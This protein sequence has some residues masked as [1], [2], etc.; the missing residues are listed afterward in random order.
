MQRIAHLL[1][2]F[3]AALLGMRAASA[4]ELRPPP[5]PP[6]ESPQSPPQPPAVPPDQVSGVA[7]PEKEPRA[8]DLFWIPRALLFVPRWA[9]W[10]AVQPVRLGAWAYGRYLGGGSG[11]PGRT[12]TLSIYPI[13]RID[14]SY[15]LTAGARLV[16]RNVIGGGERLGLRADFSG[17]YRRTFGASLRSGDRFGRRFVAELAARYE[18]RPFERFSGIGDTAELEAPPAMQLDPTAASFLTRFREDRARAVLTGDVRITG[19]LW[20]RLSAALT[21]RS[22]GAAGP[23]AADPSIEA[24]YDTSMLPGWDRGVQNLHVGA[25]LS[26][27]SRRPG[28]PYQPAALPATGWYASAYVF[29]ARGVGG[30]P[31]DHVRYGAE[32]LRLFDLYRG[33]RVLALR[34]LVDSIAGSDG[35]TDGKISFVELP[36]LGGGALLRGYPSGRF[37][38][39]ARV[40]GTA[41]YT[42]DLGNFLAAY[43][44]VDAGRVLPSLEDLAGG[45]RLRVGY[46]GGVQVHTR[47][48]FLGRIQLAA[49]RDGDLQ[50]ELVLQPAFGSR[51]RPGRW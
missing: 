35:R 20:A 15:G 33:T 9:F 34:V 2:L 39:R 14:S 36:Q 28:S 12:R 10:L 13:V 32:A 48:S 27:D 25:E 17:R 45:G 47:S 19:P 21:R 41:E 5:P 50:L 26:Y 51:G 38:D 6:P 11:P 4:E 42:W 40:L 7:H 29:G 31:S 43:A 18:S 23:G 22:F 24:A 3:A 16:H 8:H 44:F 46:G 37:R 49:S 30:D 1:V